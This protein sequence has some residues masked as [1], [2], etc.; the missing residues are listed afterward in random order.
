MSFLKK[1]RK[2]KTIE[3]VI[4]TGIDAQGDIISGRCWI[5]IPVGEPVEF[6][7][8]WVSNSV[9]DKVYEAKPARASGT[10]KA[11]LGKGKQ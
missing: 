2:P 11:E 10:F 8:M 7:A 3:G 5:D 9:S 1:L 4:P 6:R